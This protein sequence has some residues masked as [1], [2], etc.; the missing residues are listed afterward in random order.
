M[1]VVFTLVYGGI[2]SAVILKALD[3]T[4]GLRVSSE[5]EEMGLDVALHGEEGYH[6]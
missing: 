6:L 2:V 3:A 5:E 4:V 1:S